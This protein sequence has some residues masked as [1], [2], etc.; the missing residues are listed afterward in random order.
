MMTA[1][2]GLRYKWSTAQHDGR[3]VLAQAAELATGY[4]AVRDADV[5]IARAVASRDLTADGF[6]VVSDDELAAVQR[7]LEDAEDYWDVNDYADSPDSDDED[8]LL[9]QLASY[10]WVKAYGIPE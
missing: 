6:T 1:R 9:G 5:K 8:R 7:I 10:G 2:L 3:W 4:D